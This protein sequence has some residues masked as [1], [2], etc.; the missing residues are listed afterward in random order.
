MNKTDAVTKILRCYDDFIE[1][2]DG[3]IKVR[4]DLQAAIAYAV[5]F[6]ENIQTAIEQINEEVDDAQNMEDY[7]EYKLGYRSDYDDNAF[8]GISRANDILT[9]AVEAM[10]MQE[11]MECIYNNG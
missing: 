2:K 11:V 8:S 5:L 1:V 9:A 6:I 4:T 10:K 3:E 7:V